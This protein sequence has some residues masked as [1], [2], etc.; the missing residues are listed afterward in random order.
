MSTAIRGRFTKPSLRPAFDAF[1]EQDYP[2]RNSRT[3]DIATGGRGFNV[4]CNPGQRATG[5]SSE[6]MIRNE[7]GQ[8]DQSND[9]P[10]LKYLMKCDHGMPAK[11]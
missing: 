5:S 3:L 11:S 6:P 2:Q 8:A 1:Q 10:Y 4:G 9:Q 7:G